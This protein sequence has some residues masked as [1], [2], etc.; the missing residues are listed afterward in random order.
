MKRLEE[1]AKFN[2]YLVSE[3]FPRE[4]ETKKQLLHLLQKVAAE[5]AMGQSDLNEL[6]TKVG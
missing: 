3:K 4:L 1:E 6:E 5:P 2:S